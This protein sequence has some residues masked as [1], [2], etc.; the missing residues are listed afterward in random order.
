PAPTTVTVTLPGSASG[1]A[2]YT[3]SM[4]CGANAVPNPT[5]TQVVAEC[6]IDM[7]RSVWGLARAANAAGAALDYSYATAAWG[8]NFTLPAWQAPQTVV[9]DFGHTPTTP[10]IVV[11]T[12]VDVVALNGGLYDEESFEQVTPTVA[13]ATFQIPSLNFSR[14]NVWRATVN[15]GS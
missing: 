14:F 13:E 8:A 9:L 15:H 2:T 5:G 10:S 4:G 6:P 7:N 12:Y 3:L 11:S 1:A